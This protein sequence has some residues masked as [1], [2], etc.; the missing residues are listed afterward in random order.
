ARVIQKFE[1]ANNLEALARAR[2]L[3][4]TLPPRVGGSV[5]LLQRNPGADVLFLGHVGFEAVQRL[6]HLINGELIDQEIRVRFWRVR[7]E[8]VPKSADALLLWIHD[9]WRTFDQ[10]IGQHR[11]PAP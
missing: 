1:A 6:N 8:D 5:H 7:A 4:H 11:K 10:W 3:E 2:E 9:R